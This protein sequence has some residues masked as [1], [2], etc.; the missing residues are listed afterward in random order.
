MRL[1]PANAR[2]SQRQSAATFIDDQMTVCATLKL[3]PR[4]RIK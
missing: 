4:L 1:F 2:F 3:P